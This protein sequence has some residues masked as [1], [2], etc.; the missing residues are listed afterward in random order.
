MQW[1]LY[2][3]LSCDRKNSPRM[4]QHR[5]TGVHCLLLTLF[6][7]SLSLF[8]VRNSSLSFVGDMWVVPKTYRCSPVPKTHRCQTVCQRR[9]EADDV[10]LFYWLFDV[11]KPRIRFCRKPKKSELPVS[12]DTQPQE[13]RFLQA[14]IQALS[15]LLTTVRK[16][17]AR[18]GMFIVALMENELKDNL[19]RKVLFWRDTDANEFPL[20]SWS[21]G[22]FNFGCWSS[23]VI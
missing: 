3:C 16:I 2:D 9:P 13:E 1:W 21:F 23:L 6:F 10:E 20:N 5:N 22:N 8:L 19:Y 7:V 15:G 18:K 11:T 14:Q 12:K 4:L 17:L